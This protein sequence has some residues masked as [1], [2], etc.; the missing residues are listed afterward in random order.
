MTKRAAFT[1][2]DVAKV[3]KGCKQA[4]AT[5]SRI[6]IAPDGRIVALFGKPEENAHDEDDEWAKRINA[7]R[8]ARSPRE[9]H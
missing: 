8:K 7:F 1:Q 4:G 9:R 6:E 3:L 2:S 5:P